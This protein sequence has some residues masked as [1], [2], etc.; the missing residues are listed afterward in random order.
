M[1]RAAIGS[2]AERY[3]AKASGVGVGPHASDTAAA[4]SETSLI[5]A[6]IGGYAE[7]YRAKASGV[8]VGPHASE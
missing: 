7:R 1:I 4:R 8:G 5:R 3:R 6:A 2:Y